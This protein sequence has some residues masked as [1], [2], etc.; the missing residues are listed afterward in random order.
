MEK[1]KEMGKE[2]EEI[3]EEE[4]TGREMG[5]GD[6]YVAYVASE[7]IFSH[8]RRIWNNS[9]IGGLCLS[10]IATYLRT[11]IHTCTH[12]TPLISSA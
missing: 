9:S 11:R 4:K 2:M 3:E 5:G 12:N 1:E 6:N 8:N 10:H 7:I